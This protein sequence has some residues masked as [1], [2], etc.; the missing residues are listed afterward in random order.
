[1]PSGFTNRSCCAPRPVA[2]SCPSFALRRVS[3]GAH[4]EHRKRPR[5]S[6]VTRSRLSM[7]PAHRL[8]ER[9]GPGLTVTVILPGARL[10]NGTYTI[11]RARRH[12][13]TP[14]NR[15]IPIRNPNNLQVN[16]PGLSIGER[17][18]SGGRIVRVDPRSGL[19]LVI[20]VQAAS[21][22]PVTG[23]RSEC[24]VDRPYC[25]RMRK[26]QAARVVLPPQRP[27]PG[28][29]RPRGLDHHRPLGGAWPADSR[30]QD[31]GRGCGRRLTANAAG[32]SLWRAFSHRALRDSRP[33]A[34]PSSCGSDAGTSPPSSPLRPM[35]PF[36]LGAP[37]P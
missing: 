31:Y 2:R 21:S 27:Y 4:P 32:A 20:P 11:H 29:K 18:W 9:R 10:G 15:Q 25:F 7:P 28:R 1:M 33:D 14:R 16:P 23:G 24:I 36:W 35:P 12:R 17:R 34:R 5:V 6:G 3:R 37:G 30:R 22:L 19:N 13:W 8:Q 26:P